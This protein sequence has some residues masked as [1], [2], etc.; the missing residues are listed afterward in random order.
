MGKRGRLMGKHRALIGLTLPEDRRVEPGEMFEGSEAGG[1]LPWLIEQGHV[2]R[3]GPV[4]VPAE[5]SKKAKS[6][7]NK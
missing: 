7:G 6:G 4:D 1:S 3:V 5:K 2:E